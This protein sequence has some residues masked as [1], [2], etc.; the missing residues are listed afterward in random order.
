MQ[1]YWHSR[2]A[3]SP[4]AKPRPCLLRVFVVQCWIDVGVV[5]RA[6]MCKSCASRAARH[7]ASGVVWWRVVGVA[8][9]EQC[10]RGSLCLVFSD[11]DISATKGA[12]E[13]KH[14][15]H[16]GRN[17]SQNRGSPTTQERDNQLMK[18]QEINQ[19]RAPGKRSQ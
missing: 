7:G 15:T 14:Y 3:R 4:E 16:A 17:S 10:L 11:Q 18:D 6:L 8:E 1:S 5:S 9:S 12:I 19:I 2:G 13:W